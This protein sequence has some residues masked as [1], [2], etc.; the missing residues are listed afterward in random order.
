M[1]Y[2][3]RRQGRGLH[4]L[5][6]VGS[7][8]LRIRVLWQPSSP[9]PPPL[10]RAP[11]AAGVVHR[12]T[13]RGGCVAVKRVAPRTREQATTFVREVEALSMLRHPHVMQVCAGSPSAG[14]LCSA[15]RGLSCAFEMCSTPASPPSPVFP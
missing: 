15:L 3:K 6:L 12:A 8:L 9:P 4:A 2:V 10:G 1:S 11:S 13:W 7:A 14:V 5:L